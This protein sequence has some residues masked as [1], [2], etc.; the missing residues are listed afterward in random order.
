MEKVILEPVNP[1][2]YTK[3][4]L[5]PQYTTY[6]D[7]NRALIYLDSQDNTLEL[8]KND[9]QMSTIR[10]LGDSASILASGITRIGFYSAAIFYNIPNVNPR[11]DLIQF[12]SS[13]TNQI[14]SVN[15]VDG[16][17]TTAAGLMNAIE[18]ALNTVTASSGLTFAYSAVTGY[19]SVFTLTATGGLYYFITTCPA[20]MYGYQ[21]WNLPTDQTPTASKKV[22]SIDLWYTR[23]VDISCETVVKYSKVKT[24][25]TAKTPNLVYRLFINDAT[26][27]HVIPTYELPLTV[28]YNYLPS[29]PIYSFK[30]QLFDQFGNLLYI[31]PGADGTSGG[32]F[33]DIQL[34]ISI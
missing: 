31:P 29:E 32:F 2:I 19:S 1:A 25:T 3:N 9:M 17:Y 8:N 6:R 5:E 21:L 30:F 20:V 22:G 10:Q 24:V 27:P 4:N 18:N 26:Y 12:H 7:P 15:V 28:S 34:L 11:N 14:Y 16:F 13:V 23:Y 33:W